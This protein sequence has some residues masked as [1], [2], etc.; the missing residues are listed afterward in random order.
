MLNI[1]TF[2]VNPLHENC[3]VVSDETKECVII[4]CGAFTPEEQRDIIEYITCENLKP[5]RLIATHGHFDHNLGIDAMYKAF[6][7]KLEL[8]SGDERLVRDIKEQ[9]GTMCGI[10]IDF[11]PQIGGF[12]NGND[13][14][15]VGSH[16]LKVIATPGHSMGGLCYYCEEENV[17]FTGDTLFRLSIG[18]TDLPGGSMFMII[19]SLRYLCQLPDGVTVYPGHGPQTELGYEVARNPYLDR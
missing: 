1:K 2:E 8:H 6:G 11:T 16:K 9:A 14:I 3:Y 12:L 15:L 10:M 13:E 19:N 17:L 18:R 4:D 7:M 5:K